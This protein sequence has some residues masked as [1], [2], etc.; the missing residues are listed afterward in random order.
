MEFAMKFDWLNAT[1]DDEWTNDAE[2]PEVCRDFLLDAFLLA[3]A[4]DGSDDTWR[5]AF[6]AWGLAQPRRYRAVSV[7]PLHGRDRIRICA[8]RGFG[9]RRRYAFA[10]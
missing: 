5:G 2:G 10:S 3:S 7:P 4:V 6:Y 9:S 1:Y 8:L